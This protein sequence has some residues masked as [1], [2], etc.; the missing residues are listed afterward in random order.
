MNIKEQ[1]RKQKQVNKPTSVN[2]PLPQDDLERIDKNRGA[3]SRR[4]WLALAA[5][6]YLE[7]EEEHG[8]KE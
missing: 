1:L 4:Q 7:T 3:L 8:S 2:L 5:K 6:H